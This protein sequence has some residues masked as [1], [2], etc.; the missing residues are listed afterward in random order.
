MIKFLL[1]VLLLPAVAFAQPVTVDKPVTV[2][3]PVL[4]STVEVVFSE[5][6]K[7]YE[8]QPIWIGDKNDSKVVV[9][10][11]KSTSTWTVVQFDKK[12]ACVLDGGENFQYKKDFFDS[13]PSL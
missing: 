6:T 12:T 7:K 1:G 9:F 3:K 11:N 2:N 4:C 5:L 13:T 10:V 8:E